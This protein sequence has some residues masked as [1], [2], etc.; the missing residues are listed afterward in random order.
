MILLGSIFKCVFGTLIEKPLP[1][2]SPQSPESVASHIVT[3][4]LNADDPSL[5]YKQLNEEISVNAWSDA[6]ARATLHSL[7]SAIRASV[8]MARAATDAA[9]QSKDAAVS[10]GTD[11][12]VYSTLI[13]MGILA[14]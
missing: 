2:A 13:A 7:E 8:E 5:L 4:I 3:K 11:H 9:N 6:I 10:F 14:C 12:P 1:P